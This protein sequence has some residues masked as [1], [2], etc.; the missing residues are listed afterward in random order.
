MY[1]M[2]EMIK[3]QPDAIQYTIERC[4]RDV[5]LSSKLIRRKRIYL[6]GCGS[7]F[8]AAI[9]GECVLRMFGF[10]VHAVNAFDLI[11]YTPPLKNS[12][13]III[14]HSWKTRTTLKALDV[15][16]DRRIPCIGIS[17]NEKAKADV[18][19]LLRTSD[20]YDKSDC[21]TMGYTT[22]LVALALLAEFDAKKKYIQSIPSL[23]RGIFNVEEQVKQLAEK[24]HSC[25]RFFVL[26]AGPNTAT[27][28]EMALKMKE[29]NFT[30]SEAMHVEQMLHGS[31]SG[32]DEGDIVFLIAPKD[33]KVRQRMYETANVLNDIDASTVAVTDDAS[34]I[35]KECKHAIIIP[36]VPEYLNPILSIVPLQLFAYYLAEQNGINPDLA[37]EDDPKY[38]RAYASLLLHLK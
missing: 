30:D 14:S 23:L 28:H 17:A 4:A 12:I 22:K 37:R 10:D 15:L 3:E 6:T 11:H 31:I 18:D 7:S 2:Y 9:Y 20:H 8:H 5:E 33:G 35:A 32:V 38:K 29:G 26:G 25:K 13:T 24:Y 27:A 19:I 16:N 34:E 21:V 1:N 36:Y